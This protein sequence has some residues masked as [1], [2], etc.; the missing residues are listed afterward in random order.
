MH[1]CLL[2]HSVIFL[3]NMVDSDYTLLALFLGYKRYS[4]YNLIFIIIIIRAVEMSW[5][6]QTKYD[7]LW[8]LKKKI[9]YIFFMQSSLFQI[10]F[11]LQISKNK[12][13]FIQS[14]LIFK[15]PKDIF[16]Q[17]IWNSLNETNFF[18]SLWNPDTFLLCIPHIEM[19][20]EEAFQKC[21]HISDLL[22]L[23]NFIMIIIYCSI[24]F[25]HMHLYQ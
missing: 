21:Q 1:I 11:L 3:Y 10:S 24:Y 16:D 4:N 20:Q 23:I 12:I 5:M 19:W 13:F 22:L 6:Y 17:S 18:S 9:Q 8:K 7:M 25:T 2:Q 15:Y 14:F